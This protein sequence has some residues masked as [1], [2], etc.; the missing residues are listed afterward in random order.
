[1]RLPCSAVMIEAAARHHDTN[2]SR[3]ANRCVDGSP[4]AAVADDLAVLS[5]MRPLRSSA[6][7]MSTNMPAWCARALLGFVRRSRRS[8]PIP[9]RF[10]V[11]HLPAQF[12]FGVDLELHRHLEP[13][14][15][16][17]LGPSGRE[18]ATAAVLRIARAG[19]ADTTP[20][21]V[22]S[23]ARADFV[24]HRERLR[25]VGAPGGISRAIPRFD[26]LGPRPRILVLHQRHRRHFAA[27]GFR[28]TCPYCA[29]LLGECCATAVEGLLV[30][31]PR[32]GC[33]TTENARRF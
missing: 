29:R 21:C 14:L 17:C 1:M 10:R 33:G 4:R 31:S 18:L 9:R 30:G 26:C 2:C 23:F 13:R 7:G 16:R 15:A 22:V 6:S 11:E 19:A 25:H 24:A 27:D 3:P 20:N 12:A 32:E 28:A 5:T 8:Y